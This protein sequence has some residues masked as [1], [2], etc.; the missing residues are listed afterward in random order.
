MND[1]TA[2]TRHLKKLEKNPRDLKLQYHFLKEIEQLGIEFPALFP[3]RHLK[4]GTAQFPV[5]SATF[6]LIRN[7][8]QHIWDF[9]IDTDAPEN[10][11]CRHALDSVEVSI[12]SWGG[13]I[14]LPPIDDL[15]D[16]GFELSNPTDPKNG[17]FYFGLCAQ[18]HMPIERIEAHFERRIGPHYLLRLKG[19]VRGFYARPTKIELYSWIERLA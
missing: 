9:E 6:S 16:Q 13:K 10:V 7:N 4:M 8:N 3:Q 2:I 18:T 15:T 14:P 19:F 11:T 17:E 1:R 5:S 12:Y